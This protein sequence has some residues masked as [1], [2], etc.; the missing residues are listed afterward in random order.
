[1]DKNQFYQLYLSRFPSADKN[2]IDQKYLQFQ[3]LKKTEIKS[4]NITDSLKQ[5]QPHIYYG[6]IDNINRKCFDFIAKK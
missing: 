6:M 1:M 2:T 4:Q 3:K 5:N